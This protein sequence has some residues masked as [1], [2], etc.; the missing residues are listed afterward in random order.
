MNNDLYRNNHENT[1]V[2]NWLVIF[3]PGSVSSTDSYGIMPLFFKKNRRVGN[4]KKKKISRSSKQIRWF[5]SSPKY[6]SNDL[7]LWIAFSRT[8]YK[9]PDSLLFICM[10]DGLWQSSGRQNLIGMNICTLIYHCCQ[11]DTDLLILK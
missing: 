8:K 10:Q 7:D 9:L 5:L 11:R 2:C 3:L 6:S 1:I 4:I